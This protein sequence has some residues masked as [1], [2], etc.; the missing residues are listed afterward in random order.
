MAGQIGAA[1][2][3]VLQELLPVGADVDG[4]DGNGG[5]ALW[6]AAGRGELGVVVHLVELG[7]SPT[8]ATPD[9]DGRTPLYTAA[10]QG[11]LEVVQWLAGH[12]G[13]VTQPSN[14]GT[15]PPPMCA[16]WKP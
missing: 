13:S 4:R 1:S 2:L 12:G 10:R 7:A 8:R 14:D 9:N 6:H 15:T 3:A 5:S 11:H 16:V